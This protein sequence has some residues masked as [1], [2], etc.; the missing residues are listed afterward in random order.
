MT[1]L[2]LNVLDICSMF[3]TGYYLV[4]LFRKKIKMNWI[5]LILIG[6][7]AFDIIGHMLKYEENHGGSIFLLL[8]SLSAL[9]RTTHIEKNL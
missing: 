2:N 8:L 9:W 6:I 7:L 3:L 4:F 5:D 1:K